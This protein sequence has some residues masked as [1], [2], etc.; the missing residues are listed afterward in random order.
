MTTILAKRLVSALLCGSVLLSTILASSILPSTPSIKHVLLRESEGYHDEVWAPFLTDLASSPYIKTTFSR[1]YPRWNIVNITDRIQFVNSPTLQGFGTS[2]KNEFEIVPQAIIEHKV[3]YILD[4]SCDADLFYRPE[5]YQRLYH[6]TNVKL[7]CVNHDTHDYA[8]ALKAYNDVTKLYIDSDRITFIVLS[9]HVGKALNAQMLKRG[10]KQIT[11]KV[12]IPVL[13]LP[14]GIETETADQKGK[15]FVI[16][17]NLEAGRRDYG[18]LFQH[19][20]EGLAAIPAGTP[21]SEQPRLVLIGSGKKLQ[22]PQDLTKNVEIHMNLEYPEF[23]RTLG[24][25]AVLLPA[26]GTS[27]YYTAKASSTIN[28]AII[29]GTVIVGNQTMLNSYT[30]LNDKIVFLTNPGESDVQ[31]AM[32]YLALDEKTRN[33]RL[34]YIRKY[35]H[36]LIQQNRVLLD[37]LINPE[38]VADAKSIRMGVGQ[39]M[40]KAKQIPVQH[41]HS[42]GAGFVI[43]IAMVLALVFRRNIVRQCR[44]WKSQYVESSAGRAGIP[45]SME[46]LNSPLMRSSN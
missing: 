38:A 39:Y 36:D 25:S 11:Y 45:V 6:Q 35:R 5:Y 9:E 29:G 8:G 42:S 1:H 41:P 34:Q 30:F 21:D 2:N 46:Q 19:L 26:F 14:Q 3:D 33:E 27:E 24:R 15:A 32:R 20:R 7:L 43:F 28:A 40:D 17:G 16:Q 4:V 12:Y 37:E 31:A 22:V 13:D 10:S 18:T 44:A 23:Y